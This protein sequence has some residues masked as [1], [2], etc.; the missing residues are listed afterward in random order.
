MEFS[1]RLV[2]WEIVDP[3]VAHGHKTLRV[4]LPVLVAVSTEP[5]ATVVMILIGIAHC[6]PVT[7]KSPK[8]FDESIVGRQKVATRPSIA[9]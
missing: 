1:I 6:D 4:E 3:R 5:I 2:N 9:T 7:I 8:I